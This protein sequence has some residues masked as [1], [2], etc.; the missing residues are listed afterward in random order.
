MLELIDGSLVDG[1]ARGGLRR[2]ADRL[3]GLPRLPQRGQRPR[4]LRGPAAAPPAPRRRRPA[5]R[6]RLGDPA[7]VGGDPAPPA[8]GGHPRRPRRAADA[9][10]GRRVVPAGRGAGPQVHRG[11]RAA[12]APARPRWSGRCAPRSTRWRR[13]APSRPSTS[14]TCTSCDRHKI[15][16]AVGGPPGLGR[17]RAA[18]A[19]RPASSPSTRRW[20]TP[21]GS[22]S[23]ARSSARSA[24]RRSGR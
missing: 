1:P 8:D 11:L 22:T 24:A 9:H 20:S 4:L 17:A 12:R 23:P 5:R 21:S 16:H 18:T 15:V 6:G 3:P 7:P 13:S 10:P 2:G 14:C 19:G